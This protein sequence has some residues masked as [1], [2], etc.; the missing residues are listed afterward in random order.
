MRTSAG[1]SRGT[2][3]RALLLL[4]VTALLP[5]ILAAK[6][7]AGLGDVR[8]VRTWSHADY[9]RVVVELTRPVDTS[10]TRLRPNSKAGRPDRLYLDFE[11]I[12]VGRDY[13]DGIQVR[14]GLL[15][16]V[17]LGQNTLRRT[18]LV[19]DLER[20][21]SHRLLILQ[22]P[23]RVVVDVYGSRKGRKGMQSSG[24]SG[25]NGSGS[26]RLSP[27]LRS[28][29]T[30]VIDPGHGGKDPG[31]IGVGN[32]REKD[33]TLRVARNLGKRLAARGLRVV[34]TRTDDRTLSLEAR[35]AAAESVDG[36]V[37]ISV[38]ANA[39]PRR[40][41]HGVETYYLDHN[42]DRHAANLAARENGIPRGQ[43]NVLQHTLAK[44]HMEEISPHSR[45][46]ARA[47][48]KQIVSGLPK[49][50]RPQDLGVK[51]G[52]FYVLF[53]S[54]MPAILVEVGF[55]TNRTEAKRL[56]DGRY[57]DSLARQI[58][59]GVQHYASEKTASL[60]QRSAR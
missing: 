40:S 39:A 56:R 54:N 47:V 32:L 59:S 20:Y 35:T 42:H 24:S 55:L 21:E 27:S 33:V 18:R 51:K 60:A 38:H 2:C 37:F 45:R 9:T 58:A 19:I 36:D 1:I 4:C 16:D 41:V 12:W 15:Q 7:P 49:G 44:L 48:Q 28:I 43:V 29:Q 22:S 23:H 57:L 30:V 6:R 5:G 17:R 53:L 10:V 3:R 26:S 8:D 52:P 14:D 34:Y 13:A 46:L 50:K 25:A 11:G 31:A